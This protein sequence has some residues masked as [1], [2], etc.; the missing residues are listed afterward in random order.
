[1]KRILFPTDFSEA[2]KNAFVYALKLADAIKAEV[3]TLHAYE[4]PQL[5]VGRLPNTIKEVY[6]NI[7]LENFDDFKGQIPVLREIAEKYQLGHV[8]LTNM[9]KHGD[10]IWTIKNVVKEEHIDYVVMGTKG[11]TGLKETFLGSNTGSVITEVDAIVIGVPESSEFTGIHNI[12]FSTR[13]REKDLKAI[14]QLVPLA[15]LFGAKIHCL[16]I[17]TKK[18][19]VNPVVIEDW[20]FLLKDANVIFHTVESE[21]V[22]DSILN[23]VDSYNIDMLAMLNYKRGFFE[24]LFKQSLTQKLSYHVKV[25]ILALHENAV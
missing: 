10:I 17:K 22:K 16:Y 15:E 4:L 19:D 21:N 7:E 3:I 18:S 2:S 14:K 6:D 5:N 20:K 1:M 9:L 12:V 11:A 8:K 24:E 13:Y 23:F 25:P